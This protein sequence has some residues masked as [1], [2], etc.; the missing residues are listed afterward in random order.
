MVQARAQVL[1]AF[2]VP[3]QAKELALLVPQA[4]MQVKERPERVASQAQRQARA[5]YHQVK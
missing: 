2:L 4:S 3:L 5:R 1:P